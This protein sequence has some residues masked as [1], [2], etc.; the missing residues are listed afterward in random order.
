MGENVKEIKNI[1]KVGKDNIENKVNKQVTPTKEISVNFSN[2]SK[3]PVES[4]NTQ[5]NSKEKVRSKE[6]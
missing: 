4:V 6:I 5:K 2:N 3:P 1:I